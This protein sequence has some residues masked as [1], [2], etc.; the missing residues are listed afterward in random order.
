MWNVPTT[1]PACSPHGPAPEPSSGPAPELAGS[2]PELAGSATELAG[3]TPE[4]AGPTPE[5]TGSATEL[6]GPTPEL[7][8]SATELAGSTTELTGSTP[9]GWPAWSHGLERAVPE[10]AVKMG[11][12]RVTSTLACAILVEPLPDIGVTRDEAT[13]VVGMSRRKN[14]VHAGAAAMFPEIGVIAEAGNGTLTPVIEVI[15]VGVIAT[16]PVGVMHFVP[17]SDIAPPPHEV[18]TVGD[19]RWGWSIEQDL[20][21]DKPRW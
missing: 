19:D 7:A 1:V 11:M 4:L 13:A 21:Q 3:S 2:A 10:G 6:T 8:G 5:L 9:H 12:G 14:G 18:R 15:E 17:G 16:P 20:R